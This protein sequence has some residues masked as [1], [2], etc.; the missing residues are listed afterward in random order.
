MLG[1][2]SAWRS[3]ATPVGGDRPGQ[4][5]YAG[6]RLSQRGVFRQI[7]RQVER[8][9]GGTMSFVQIVEFNTSRIDEIKAVEEQWR[10]ETAGKRP[11]AR[12]TICKDR[13]REGHYYVIAEFPSYEEAMRNSNLPETDGMSRQMANLTDGP[14]G[15]TNL[16]V[17]DVHAD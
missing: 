15:F 14:P 9:R 16:D 11:S 3:A 8:P 12:V 5:R 2:F 1:T 10:K 7:G 6:F 4:T 17:L 13:D